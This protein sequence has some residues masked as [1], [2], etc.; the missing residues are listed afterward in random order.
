MMYFSYRVGL[1]ILGTEQSTLLNP[2]LEWFINQLNVI[3]QPLIVGSLACGIAF[4]M[5][6]FIAIRL[7]YR[8]RIARYKLKKLDARKRRKMGTIEP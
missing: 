8:W 3:W 2:S 7:Y 1:S 5:A 6:G 4:G